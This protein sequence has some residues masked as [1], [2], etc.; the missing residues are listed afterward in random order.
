MGMWPT[1]QAT[2]RGKQ[3]GRGRG[4]RRKVSVTWWSPYHARVEKYGPHG[5]EPP[6]HPHVSCH[7]RTSR[8]QGLGR[9]IL[10]AAVTISLKAMEGCTQ[11]F[12]PPGPH[13]LALKSG[14]TGTKS[15]PELQGPCKPTPVHACKEKSFMFVRASFLLPHIWPRMN[16]FIP[17]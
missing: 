1:L 12:S 10:Q 7:N 4:G 5:L 9:G 8:T 13:F 3:A 14:T 15:K 6:I 11:S 16:P 17:P 2:V